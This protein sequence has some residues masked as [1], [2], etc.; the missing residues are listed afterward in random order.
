MLAKAVKFPS[1][2]ALEVL[3]GLMAVGK[4]NSQ[5]AIQLISLR[6]GP[7]PFMLVCLMREMG[8]ML[9]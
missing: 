3:R 1:E 5:R 9:M 8:V 4:S 2:L 7:S 6:E